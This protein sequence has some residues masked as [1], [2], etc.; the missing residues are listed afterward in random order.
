MNVVPDTQLAAAV[1]NELASMQ[2]PATN[3]VVTYIMNSIAPYIN[4][5]AAQAN[6]A[7]NA[8]ESMVHSLMMQNQQ[9]IMEIARLRQTHQEMPR[10][11]CTNPA[12][13][14]GFCMDN[15]KEKII[16]K[17]RI[18]HIYNCIIDKNKCSDELLY[19]AYY[20]ADEQLHHTIV[21]YDKLAG[22]NL[23]PLFKYFRYI[24]RSKELAN[25]YL[26]NCIN[27]FPKKDNFYFPEYCGFSFFT[28]SDGKEA[29]RFDCNNNIIEMQ[30]LKECSPYYVQKI[31]PNVYINNLG[32]MEI[33]EK[34]RF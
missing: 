1:N 4:N 34:Y 13:G 22:K 18:T 23:L 12:N 29:V 16:G 17:L 20:D 32:T 30:L 9:Q 24:C 11:F 33:C 15:G 28:G 19:I 5:M 2:L 27:N 26:A 6:F 14:F 10:M 3:Q 8:Y 31:L 25:D 7:Y 21:P